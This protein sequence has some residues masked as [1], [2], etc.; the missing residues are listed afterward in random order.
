MEESGKGAHSAGIR[1]TYTY[2]SEAQDSPSSYQ[3]DEQM[4][5]LV[6]VVPSEVPSSSSSSP[7]KD[8]HHNEIRC[9]ICYNLMITS[10]TLKPFSGKEI[11]DIFNLKTKHSEDFDDPGSHLPFCS[12]CT[13]LVGDAKE[14]MVKLEELQKL[15]EQLRQQLRDKVLTS[16]EQHDVRT[17]NRDAAA[18]LK[19]K[20]MVDVEIIRQDV[21]ISN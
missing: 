20:M 10:D 4:P 12:I 18:E 21:L 2:K 16:F 9:L 6:N 7:S 14:F 11:Y 13:Q 3:W 1:K 8:Q 5:T 19:N 17:G 15:L